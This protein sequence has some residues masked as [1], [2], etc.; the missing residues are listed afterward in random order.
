MDSNWGG[1]RVDYDLVDRLERER[2]K[3]EQSYVCPM[4]DWLK[5]FRDRF[6]EQGWWETTRQIELEI[7]KLDP[8][9]GLV[10]KRDEWLTADECAGE[11]G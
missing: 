11:I 8:A 3:K 2:Y 10:I 4:W 9:R 1:R 6:T 7:I 5:D